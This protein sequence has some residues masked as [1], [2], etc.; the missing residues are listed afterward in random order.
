[1]ARALRVGLP[2]FLIGP[3]MPL[4]RAQNERL[5]G[6]PP[7]CGALRFEPVSRLYF[8]LPAAVRPP[9][10]LLCLPILRET[11]FFFTAITLREVVLRVFLRRTYYL[12]LDSHLRSGIH[13]R[14]CHLLR[15]GSNRLRLVD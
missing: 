3:F 10:R 1:M 4:K 5:R 15:L 14:R 9:L 7:G 11:F 8:F 6:P 13:V 12:L 2:F